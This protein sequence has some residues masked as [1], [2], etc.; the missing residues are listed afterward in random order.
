M[1]DFLMTLK[2]Q[3][4]ITGYKDKNKQGINWFAWYRPL[5][6]LQMFKG[7]IH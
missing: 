5:I 7:G 4:L 6:R 1:S 3:L 2:K